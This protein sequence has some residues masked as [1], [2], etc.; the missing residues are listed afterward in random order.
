M[1]CQINK[2]IRGRKFI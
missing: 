1:Y 2:N